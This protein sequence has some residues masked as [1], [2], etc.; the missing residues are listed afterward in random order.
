[1]QQLSR[2][3]QTVELNRVKF[4][5]P[6]PLI[7]ISIW[8]AGSAIAHRVLH[9][10]YMSSNQLQADTQLQMKLSVGVL[11]INADINQ[12]SNTTTVSIKT[13][14]P[15]LKTLE[16]EFSAIEPQQIETAIAQEIDLPIQ[17]VRKLVRYR[18]I[19]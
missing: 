5:L 14:D 19:E 17:E 8:F 12:R 3:F 15:D 10:S 4:W 9:T 16:Y 1:M 11:M 6:L 13:T 2:L 18:I 7:G